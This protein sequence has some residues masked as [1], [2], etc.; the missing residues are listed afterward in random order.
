MRTPTASWIR[1]IASVA[2]PVQRLRGRRQPASRPIAPPRPALF[3]LES[4][5]EGPKRLEALLEVVSQLPVREPA[6][7]LAQLVDGTTSEYRGLG[8]DLRKS[9]QNPVFVF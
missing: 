6:Y 5:E 4:F 3:T 2:A 9:L 7:Q 8:L 1:W